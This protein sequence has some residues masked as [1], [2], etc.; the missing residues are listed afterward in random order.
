MILEDI[1]DIWINADII[2]KFENIEILVEYDD[3]VIVPEYSY[4]QDDHHGHIVTV[5]LIRTIVKI[6]SLPH[7]W[8]L[9]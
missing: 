1:V 6:F 8:Q 3:S 7:T 2:D 5:T 9:H 4:L